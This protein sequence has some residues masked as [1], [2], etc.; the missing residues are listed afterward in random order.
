[1]YSRYFKE[2]IQIFGNTH[3]QRF[4]QNSF[5]GAPEGGAGRLRRP[6]KN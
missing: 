6:I 3:F 4:L 2:M 5:P 1:M